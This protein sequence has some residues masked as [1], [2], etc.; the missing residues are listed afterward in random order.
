MPEIDRLENA[1][2]AHFEILG[3]KDGKR[4][5]AVKEL[6]SKKMGELI[7]PIDRCIMTANT[8]AHSVK[9]EGQEERQKQVA[10]AEE[11][12]E[13]LKKE[14]ADGTITAERFKE[15]AFEAMIARRATYPLEGENPWDTVEPEDALLDDADPYSFS[16]WDSV[17][18]PLQDALPALHQLACED[19]EDAPA[20]EDE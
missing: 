19:W 2:K 7:E 18:E 17:V 6:I 8:R 5:D 11:S 13:A 15:V 16:I 4:S 1:I 20:E 3:C 9:L 10:A 14:I 12:L